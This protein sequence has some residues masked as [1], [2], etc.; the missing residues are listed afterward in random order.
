[1]LVQFGANKLSDNLAR[2]VNNENILGF[3]NIF[4]TDSSEER[5]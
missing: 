2:K 4:I 1:M 3:E 5:G